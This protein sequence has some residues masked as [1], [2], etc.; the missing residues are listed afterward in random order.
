MSTT[1]KTTGPQ[2]GT[3]Q[4]TQM[5]ALITPQE[6]LRIGK[7]KAWDLDLRGAQDT[8]DQVRTKVRTRAHIT[9]G[10]A[11]AG[12]ADTAVAADAGEAVGVGEDG[13]DITGVGVDTTAAG[14]A[15]EPGV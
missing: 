6:R 10:T 5:P 7:G 14:V 4:Q 11:V 15:V 13:V 8:A 3:G 12:Q 1:D 2:Q 9:A